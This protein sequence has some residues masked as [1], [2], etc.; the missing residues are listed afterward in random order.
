[1]KIGIL[2]YHWVY[3]FGANL[4][5][6]ILSEIIKKLGH[7]PIVI[8]YKSPDLIGFYKDRV[9]ENQRLLHDKF[10]SEKLSL[11]QESISEMELERIVK[12]ENFDGIIVG[13]DSLWRV[14]KD[15]VTSDIR[16]P[17]VYWL[18][19]LKGDVP[20][21]SLSV[22]TMGSLF[23]RLPLSIQNSMRRSLSKFAY[24]SVR[25]R[26]SKWMVEWV[27][28]GRIRPSVLPDPVFACSFI[29]QNILLDK[30]LSE[31]LAGKKFLICSM[32]KEHIKK[33]VWDNFK[34]QLND[35][36]YELYELPHPEGASGLNVDET[37]DLP[38]SPIEWFTW[39]H[40]SSGYIGEKFH[41]VVVSLANNKPFISIDNYT[42]NRLARLGFYYQS[43]IYDL[44][45]KFELE[46]YYFSL[47]DV[48]S[49]DNIMEKI[50]NFPSDI[51]NIN[52]NKFKIKFIDEVYKILDIFKKNSLG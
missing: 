30:S 17:N 44:L 32:Y 31:K 35:R 42:G 40:Y 6:Y 46:D 20:L 24:V 29:D 34:F 18:N 47:K 49:I 48:N 14:L 9:P 12:E 2:T 13:S 16:Y 41:P 39:F 10:I 23:P 52:V 33:S 26:W 21:A 37:I 38:L 5:V 45:K 15:G 8:N 22:S 25:D 51:T 43:K 11:T 7:E 1:M 27:S 36:G 19:W 4:Q 28:L 50:D 3:N